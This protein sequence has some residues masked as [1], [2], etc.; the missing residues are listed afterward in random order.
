[1]TM[2]ETASNATALAYSLEWWLDYLTIAAGCGFVRAMGSVVM[3]LASEDGDR[4]V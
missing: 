2:M 1:M 3:L 4:R